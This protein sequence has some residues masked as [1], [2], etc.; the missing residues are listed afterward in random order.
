MGWGEGFGFIGGGGSGGGS[1]DASKVLT[2]EDI[3][4][5][6]VTQGAYSPGDVIPKGTPIQTINKKML[7][8]ESFPSFTNPAS[9]FNVDKL[10]IQEVGAVLT[11]NFSTLFSRGTIS[12][13]YGTSGY[14][15]GLP[16][17][18]NSYIYTGTGLS[19][20]NSQSLSNSQQVSNYTIILGLQFWSAYVNYLAGEQPLS[21][22][23]NPYSTP[24]P[25]GSTSVGQIIIQGV[26]AFYATTS[27]IA[28]LTKQQLQAP[29]TI[30]QVSMV[31]E[32]GADK[33]T[34][35][36]SQDW[37]NFT[38]LQQ[39][40]TLSGQWDAISISSFTKTTIQIGGVNYYQYVHNGSTIGARQLRFIP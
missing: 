2:S 10:P 25:A 20:V 17:A 36:V 6:G 11:L 35:Q 7:Q 1:T 13:A 22:F 38:S 16:A 23:G 15:S 34:L 24:L 32:S 19:N 33:Q 5:I 14:R 18:T 30:A 37:G 12:P 8:V 29:G 3:T 28:T 27:S 26:Y 9:T 31:A 4:V 39:Y 21:S 40:N